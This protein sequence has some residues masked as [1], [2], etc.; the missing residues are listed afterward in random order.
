MQ[1]H[2]AYVSVVQITDCHLYQDPEAGLYGLNSRLG[3]EKVVAMAAKYA[4]E[5]VLLTGDIVHDETREGYEALHH[6]V[7]PLQAPVA[8]IPGNHDDFDLMRSVLNLAGLADQQA[9]CGKS[10]LF[11][12]WQ[13]ILLNSQVEGKV[14]GALSDDELDFLRYQLNKHPEHHTIICMHHHPVKIGSQWLDRIGLANADDLFEILDDSPQVKALVW[15]HVHQSFEEFRDGRY[16]LACPSTCIQFT[17]GADNFE[18]DTLTPG[19]RWFRLHDDGVLETGVE[20]LPA[21]PGQLNTE[22]S[23]Y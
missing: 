23:G 2:N 5:R 9:S 1:K 3:L 12:H 17:P 8:C 6:L 4:P 19:F 20:R 21:M 7:A 11:S 10:I 16:L 18:L 13:I 15:G 22:A 14:S